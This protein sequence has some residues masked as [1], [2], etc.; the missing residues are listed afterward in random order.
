MALASTVSNGAHSFT[1]SPSTM[2]YMALYFLVLV[3]R[4]FKL[5]KEEQG[6]KWETHN[7]REVFHVGLELVYTASG[8]VVLLLADLHAYVAFIIIGY[9]IVVYIST[10]IETMDKRF[11]SGVVFATHVSILVLVV[12]TTIW[13]FQFVQPEAQAAQNGSTAGAAQH[14]RVA[15]P[16][17]DMALREHIGA[18]YGSRQLVFITDLEAKDDFDAKEKARAEFKQKVTPFES[19]RRK[20]S[21]DD[22]ITYSDQVIVKQIR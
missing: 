21:P 10:Q 2:Y 7:W 11:S 19:R 8:L 17:Q 5:K 20:S 9:V 12:F 16:Y 15:I 6:T 1:I 13:Y 14:F 3:V 4:F 18:A 22:I